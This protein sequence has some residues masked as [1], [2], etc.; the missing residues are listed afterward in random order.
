MKRHK[1][2]TATLVEEDVVITG[3]VYA[4]AD[5]IFCGRVTGEITCRG[6][7]V[8]EE[9]GRIKGNLFVQDSDISGSVKGDIRSYGTL[10]LTSTA[11]VSGDITTK[12]IVIDEG[13]VFDGNC[14]M[15]S[16]DEETIKK[17]RNEK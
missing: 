16:Y 17:W 7:L 5:M 9:S 2:K 4:D 11:N 8:I 6:R 1:L 13:A 12:S 14:C 10:H 3:S 15:V